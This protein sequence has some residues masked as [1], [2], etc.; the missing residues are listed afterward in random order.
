M[1]SVS[2]GENSPVVALAAMPS[3]YWR[4][5]FLG[6]GGVQINNKRDTVF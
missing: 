2:D 4:P 1:R 5:F 6:G 3:H